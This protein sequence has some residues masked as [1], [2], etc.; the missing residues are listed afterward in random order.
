MRVLIAALLAVAVAISP[1]KAEERKTFSQAELDQTLAPVALYPDAL[2]S[3]VLMAATYPLEIVEAARWSR[4]HS[5]IQGDEAVRAVEDK[6]WDPSVKSLVAFPNLLARMDENLEWTRRL[7]DAFLGQE[8]QV[9][10]TIQQL[11]QRA[12]A[13]GKL[14]SDERQRVSEDGKTIVIE[15]ADPRVV[16]VPYYDPYVVY[17]SWWWPAYPPVYWA[18][19]PG[20]YAGYPGFWWGVGVGISAGFFYGGM[21]WDHHHVAVV[22]PYAYYAK[23][24]YARPYGPPPRQIQAGK[25]QHDNWH[26]RGVGQTYEMRRANAMPPAGFRA[27]SD[28]RGF[29]GRG[30][31]RGDLRPMDDRRTDSRQERRSESPRP[32]SP[33]EAQRQQ[34][35]FES[36]RAQPRS[37]SPRSAPQANAP[38]G[39]IRM[40]GPR[41]QS[42]RAEAPNA[43]PRMEAPR[44]QPRVEASPQQP[45]VQAPSAQPRVGAPRAQPSAGAPQSMPR[46]ESRGGDFRGGGGSGAARGWGGG[47]ESRGWSGGAPGGGFRGGG[48]GGGYGGSG[49]GG[50]GGSG[51]GGGGG[52][53]GRG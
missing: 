52:G 46:M 50:Y 38:R 32:Q 31:Q 44:A 12:Q 43:Q 48:G 26:R 27:T 10:D 49:G 25:W 1:V 18:P 16:Y 15:Q 23:P 14:S 2:L 47:G 4:G 3:Q 11:R 34:P 17:G 36:P 5:G 6:D 13:E 22:H 45:R 20:Y 8:A 33:G 9:M 53:R 37:E 7:G 35:R 29:A 51:G 19:W 40:E 21:S 30:D 28:N 24:G 42:S 39:Q 41:P